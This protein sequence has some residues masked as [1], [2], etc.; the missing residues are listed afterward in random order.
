MSTL[1]RASTQ[2]KRQSLSRHSWTY[3]TARRQPDESSFKTDAWNFTV[4]PTYIKVTNA[5]S[6]SVIC[7]TSCFPLHITL[8]EIIQRV[9]P[10][11]NYTEDTTRGRQAAIRFIMFGAAG[12]PV[13][14]R[15]AFVKS[16]S[17]DLKFKVLDPKNLKI[18]AGKLVFY[19]ASVVCLKLNGI[20][21]KCLNDKT[22]QPI[23]KTC[24][25]EAYD[26][27]TSKPKVMVT[28]PMSMNNK[29][30][31]LFLA[32]HMTEIFKKKYI[33]I[34]MATNDVCLVNSIYRTPDYVTF[35]LDCQPTYYSHFKDDLKVFMTLQ[36]EVILAFK[37]NPFMLCPWQG[38]W[39][40]VPI[41]YTGSGITVPAKSH[42]IVPYDNCYFTP[43][44]SN[45]TS[46]VVSSNYGSSELIVEEAEWKPGETINVRVFNCSN[47][48]FEFKNGTQIAD[49]VFIIASKYPMK[50]LLPDRVVDRL[51]TA[52]RLPGKILV[53]AT[54][55]PTFSNLNDSIHP[56]VLK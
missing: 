48:A 56:G 12:N 38:D 32:T 26:L 43:T 37:F 4:Y 14:V 22:H 10:S 5:K 41:F 21:L 18:A 25:Q 50:H 24:K 23:E 34:H 53:N 31:C 11:F 19:I 9:L 6:V 46:I 13:R 54:K 3:G 15:S 2:K 44:S 45:I 36:D 33:H 16:P 39:D 49:A 47:F 40:R 1:T 35:D 20:F 51:T 52:L 27:T 17:C 55:L 28:G 7:T 30:N 8:G 29:Q 42:A